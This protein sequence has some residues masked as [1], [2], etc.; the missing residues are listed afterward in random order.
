MSNQNWFNTLNEALEAEGLV[1]QWPLGLNIEYGG[2]AKV[3]T[4]DFLLISVF[5]DQDGR[6]ER[7][8]S[9]KTI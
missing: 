4:E 8:I 9:Y 2:T 5:R 6:Y 7:P 1:S 3:L